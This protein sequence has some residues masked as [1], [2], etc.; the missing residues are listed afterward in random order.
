MTDDPLPTSRKD[1]M[2]IGSKHYLTTEPCPNGHLEPRITSSGQCMKC[3][4]TWSRLHYGETIA[5][6][7]FRD[8]YKVSLEAKIQERAARSKNRRLTNEEKDDIAQLYDAGYTENELARQFHVK[9][10][11]VVYC[12]SAR[13]KRLGINIRLPD[14]DAEPEEYAASSDAFVRQLRE[15]YPKGSPLR[16]IEETPDERR[17]L[18]LSRPVWGSGSGSP[19][20]SCADS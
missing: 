8:R 14:G 6:L 9:E 3:K 13:R 16:D 18:V 15:A 5:M 11:F 7:A 20:Q 12:V 1:A 10:T 17:R 4:R 2:R 19:A